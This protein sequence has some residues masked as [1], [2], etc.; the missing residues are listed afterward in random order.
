MNSERVIQALR[1]VALAFVIV[2]VTITVSRITSAGLTAPLLTMMGSAA[3][4][5]VLFSIDRNA[6]TI[7]NVGTIFGT[8]IIMVGGMYWFVDAMRD[9]SA[10]DVALGRLLAISLIVG[11][12]AYLSLSIIV[13]ACSVALSRIRSR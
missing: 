2:L 12:A 1:I 4:I 3:I 5:T 10:D 9:G 13:P 8:V 7:Q 6:V 11:V